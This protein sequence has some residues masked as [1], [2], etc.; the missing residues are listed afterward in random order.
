MN[1]RQETRELLRG[2]VFVLALAGSA[3]AFNAGARAAE[4]EDSADISAVQEALDA[5]GLRDAPD[6]GATQPAPDSESIRQQRPTGEDARA[7][8][9]KRQ[10]ARSDRATRRASQNTAIPAATPS[11]ED[12]AGIDVF[13]K[14]AFQP[15]R[16]EPT[17]GR[18]IAP[19]YAGVQEGAEFVVEAKAR[20]LDASGKA[21]TISPAWVASDP[22]MVEVSP[23]AGEAV[24]ITVRDAG[25]SRLI[26]AAP[27]ITKEL[28]ISATYASRAMHVQISE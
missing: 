24:K 25:Q 5:N 4:A 23:G 3:C 16:G 21:T 6:A 12:L 1:R 9:H 27:G 14:L 17:T 28:S 19:A 8:R 13:F 10:L 7:A 11:P 2:T 18:W 26:V 22:N 20:G 15:D